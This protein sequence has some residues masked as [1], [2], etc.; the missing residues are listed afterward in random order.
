VSKKE[1]RRAARDAFPKAKSAQARGRGGAYSK[2]KYQAK[3]RAVGGAAGG[4]KRSVIMGVVAGVFFF[5]LI[6]W[7]VPKWFHMAESSWQVNVL[8]A[9]VGVLLFSGVNYLSEGFRY[10]RYV[11]KHKGSDK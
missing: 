4:I 8:T 5:V 7:I 2:R 11:S 3:P 6:Q 9:V 1:I 10:R